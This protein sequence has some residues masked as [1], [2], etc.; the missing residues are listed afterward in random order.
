MTLLSITSGMDLLL[1]PLE[2]ADDEL[3]AVDNMIGIWP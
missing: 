2:R 3:W 1:Q